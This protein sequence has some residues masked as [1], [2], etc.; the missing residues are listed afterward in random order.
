MEYT[1]IWEKV[2]NSDEMPEFVFSVGDRYCKAHL[3]VW[4]VISLPLL[5]VYGFGIIV[6]LVAYFYYG[7]YLKR[8]NAFA[9][10]NRRILVHRGWLSTGLRSIDYHQIVEVSVSERFFQ[11][12]ITRSGN[13]GIKAAGQAS[14]DVV[15]A[16]IGSPYDVKKKLD[17]LRNR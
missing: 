15:L 2:L 17:E 12:V 13:L 16:D 4:G 8:A 10:T 6:F 3:I 9:F 14:H 11:R 7:F 5:T 1:G